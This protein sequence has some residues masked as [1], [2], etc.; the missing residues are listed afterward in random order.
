[1]VNLIAGRRIVPELLQSRFNPDTLSET[2]APLLADTPTR[3]RQVADLAEIRAA[4]TSLG[5][6]GD[7]RTAIKRVR[8]AVLASLQ[9]SQALHSSQSHRHEVG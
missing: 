1:M 3:A 4:L 2:L 6:P 5:A 7:Q 9:R 8:D